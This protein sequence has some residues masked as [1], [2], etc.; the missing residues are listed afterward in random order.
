MSGIGVAC[1]L[2]A[3]FPVVM[4]P[5]GLA[6]ALVTALLIGRRIWAQHTGAITPRVAAATA[7]YPK[8]LR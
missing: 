8:A 5:V 7:A 4:G 1:L 6:A 3:I 2:V